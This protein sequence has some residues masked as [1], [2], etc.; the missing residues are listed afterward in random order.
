MR[1]IVGAFGFR[2]IQNRRRGTDLWMRL[3]KLAING[4]KLGPYGYLPTDLSTLQAELDKRGLKVSGTF[5]MD[6]LEDPASWGTLEEQVL[7]AGES[8]A[9]LGA[10][11]LVLIDDVYTD[12]FTGRSAETGST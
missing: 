6:H 7:G 1:L 5:A 11:Y 8:L 12:L 2:T 9:L 4:L 3:P 10:E